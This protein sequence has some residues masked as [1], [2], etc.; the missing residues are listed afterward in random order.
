[1]LSQIIQSLNFLIFQKNRLNYHF[2]SNS[3]DC[4]DWAFPLKTLVMDFPAEKDSVAIDQETN[5][6]GYSS[7]VFPE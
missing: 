1:M 4:T 6:K 3:R 5:N 2:S 7:V